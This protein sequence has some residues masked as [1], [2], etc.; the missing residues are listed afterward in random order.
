MI[1]STI[2]ILMNALLRYITGQ[3]IEEGPSVDLTS[4]K[5]GEG[6]T[7]VSSSSSPSLEQCITEDLGD[8][9]GV[10]EDNNDG[11]SGSSVRNLELNDLVPVKSEREKRKASTIATDTNV[12]IALEGR[13][14]KKK[15]IKEPVEY[16][17]DI[18][19]TS[20]LD[21]K[22]PLD[23][24]KGRPIKVARKRRVKM[25]NDE[26]SKHD[27]CSSSVSTPLSGR[28]FR[29]VR[30]EAHTSNGIDRNEEPS[31]RAAD[32]ATNDIIESE[33]DAVHNNPSS[34]LSLS[35]SSTK[36]ISSV[37]KSASKFQ[38][39][40]KIIENS[41]STPANEKKRGRSESPA[42]RRGRGRP[43]TSGGDVD[44][45]VG[46]PSSSVNNVESKSPTIKQGRGRPSKDNIA[47]C[48]SSSMTINGTK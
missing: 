44:N 31:G 29:F 9:N 19:E 17:R 34:L 22:L 20:K 35:G 33:D 47:G 27:S 14:Q 48:P 45:H 42:I 23:R 24:N 6:S 3:Q 40:K 38:P 13:R 4:D 43:P 18:V 8:D 36:D 26:P 12:Q 10:D 39:L 2:T 11:C 21:Q 25:C 28:F 1:M 16:Q 41:N 32:R 46:C 15:S 7:S 5:S 37:P 30:V